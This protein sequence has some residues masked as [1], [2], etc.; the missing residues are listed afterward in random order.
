MLIISGACAAVTLMSTLSL[1]ALH[2]CHYRVPKEQ[3]Q[4]VLLVFAPFV[5]AL[6]S[7]AEILDYNVAPYINPIGDVYEAFALCGLFLLYIQFAVPSG[8]FGEDMFEAMEAATEVS[9]KSKS[10]NW[11]KTSWILVFQY[12]LTALLSVLVLEGTLATGK[13]CVNSL[14]PEFGHLWTMIINTVG[15][16]LCVMTIFRL[17]K[18]MKFTMKA[19]KGL[20]KLVCFK[21]IVFLRLIQT[22]SVLA[23]RS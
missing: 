7:W 22:V 16:V 5:F 10:R 3:R 21:G 14:K 8:T 12:P 13:Y 17:Y 2:L 23:S 11:P 20:A 19:R 15:L 6:V 4:I 18:R 9:T 1:I